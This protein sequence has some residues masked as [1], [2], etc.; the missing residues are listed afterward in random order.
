[1]KLICIFLI[2]ASLLL[3]ATFATA[4]TGVQVPCVDCEQYT[5]R[6]EPFRGMWYNKDQT[7][8]GFSIDVQEGK[9]FG[10]YYGYNQAGDAI[11]QTFVG[12]LVPSAEPDIIVDGKYNPEPV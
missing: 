3:A 1:M 7:A 9:L 8:Q 4:Q 12:D 6:T 10:V 2:T 11:W 5:Q